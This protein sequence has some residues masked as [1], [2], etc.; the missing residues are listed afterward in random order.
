MDIALPFYVVGLRFDNPRREGFFLFFLVVL[1]AVHLAHVQAFFFCKL[2]SLAGEK[3][4]LLH[5]FGEKK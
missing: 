5:L 1:L 3:K 2:Q 4:I